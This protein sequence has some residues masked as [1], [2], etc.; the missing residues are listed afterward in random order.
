MEQALKAVSH[1][2]NKAPRLV[3]DK[4]LILHITKIDELNVDPFCFFWKRRA[5]KLQNHLIFRFPG[6]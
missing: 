6:L 3:L 1:K 2:I 4:T 5:W